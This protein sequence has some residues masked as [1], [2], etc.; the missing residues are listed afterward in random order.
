[1]SALVGCPY[2]GNKREQIGCWLL[3]LDR[4]YYKLW[5]KSMCALYLALLY[6]YI[7]FNFSSSSSYFF[8][9]PS[10]SW[11]EWMNEFCLCAVCGT[12]QAQIRPGFY[13]EETGREAKKIFFFFCPVKITRNAAHSIVD[14]WSFVCSWTRDHLDQQHLIPLT[15]W[16]LLCV[17]TWLSPLCLYI[18]FWYGP[19]FY[20]FLS[21][22]SDRFSR[23]CWTT[24]KNLLGIVVQVVF[25]RLRAAA[26]RVF[27]PSGLARCFFAPLVASA[28]SSSASDKSSGSMQPATSIPIHLSQS[29]LWRWPPLTISNKSYPP[30]LSGRPNT[31][32]LTMADTSCSELM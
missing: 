15:I 6:S 29:C 11:S 9:V 24:K 16:P 19:A 25:C 4:Y 2:L 18:L 13:R 12:S 23:L 7:A 5:L 14:Q 17:C 20:V 22:F 8:L 1:M 32:K 28:W 30:P 27:L 3:S 31:Y 10:Q 21:L 26:V